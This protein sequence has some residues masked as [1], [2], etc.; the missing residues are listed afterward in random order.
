[1]MRTEGE[2]MRDPQPTD[3]AKI[4]HERL[5]HELEK[6]TTI[7]GE[8]ADAARAVLKVLVP[9][10]LLEEE[11]AIPPVKLLPRLAR[12]EFTADME[13]IIPKSEMMK[14]ELPRMLNEHV[15]I[16]EA[17]RGLLQAA[18]K[19]RHE[20]YATFAQKLILHAQQEEEVFYPASILVG[21]YLKLKLGRS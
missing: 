18:L 14:A 8:T 21:E 12:G 15:L 2:P 9:H 19:E 13:R 20:G 1:M 6:A 4:E 10:M 3:G 16:V 11:F 7:G 17:L 5:R